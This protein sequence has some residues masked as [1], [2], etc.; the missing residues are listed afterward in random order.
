MANAISPGIGVSRRAGRDSGI[1]PREQLR[2]EVVREEE[3]A[4]RGPDAA[5][6]TER[7]RLAG[8]TPLVPRRDVRGP[9]PRE[10]TAHAEAARAAEREH[11][12][13]FS[14][15]PRR[16]LPAT[17]ARQAARLQGLEPALD[18][19]GIAPPRGAVEGMRAGP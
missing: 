19:I 1:A 16:Q 3:A 6:R 2:R 4:V 15:F 11:H 18:R 10:M 17:F 7:E 5:A 12:L 9:E 14:C 8:A 13:F